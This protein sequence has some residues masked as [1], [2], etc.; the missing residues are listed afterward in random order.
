MNKRIG[1]ALGLLLSILLPVAATGTC[2]S[3]IQAT[4]PTE[5]FTLDDLNGTATHAKTGLTWMRCSLGQTWESA[6]RTCSGTVIFYR[7]GEALR[8][9][10]G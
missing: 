2:L 8:A 6:T 10:Q 7:W 5:D 1:I 9:A 4:T 3:T